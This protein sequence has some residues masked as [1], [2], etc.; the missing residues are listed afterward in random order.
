MDPRAGFSGVVRTT[1]DGAVNCAAA[2]FAAVRQSA[3]PSDNARHPFTA[4]ASG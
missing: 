4:P 3:T 1:A 2:T